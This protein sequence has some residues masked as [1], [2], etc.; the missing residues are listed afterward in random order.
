MTEFDAVLER[1]VREGIV[2]AH[3]DRDTIVTLLIGPLLM[4][5]L[6][7]TVALCD[8]LVDRVVDEFFTAAKTSRRAP[9]RR[10]GSRDANG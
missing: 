1:G 5:G 10:G 3:D 4:A 2:S 9:V 8:A 6:T 7:G